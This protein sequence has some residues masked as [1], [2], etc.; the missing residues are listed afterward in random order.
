ML[1]QLSSGSVSSEIVS[2]VRD[3]SSVTAIQFVLDL[4]RQDV[5]VIAA[6]GSMIEGRAENTS[7]LCQDGGWRDMKQRT[8]VRIGAYLQ[9]IR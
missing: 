8:T 5:H 9:V 2:R 3:V 1:A 7:S 4:A 6:N